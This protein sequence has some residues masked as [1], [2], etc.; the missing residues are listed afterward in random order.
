MGD[1]ARG[2]STGQQAQHTA[3]RGLWRAWRNGTPSLAAGAHSARAKK[4]TQTGF[5]RRRTRRARELQ[6]CS[7][8]GAASSGPAVSPG[9]LSY[10]PY[11]TPQTGSSHI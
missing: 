10:A 7:A 6:C 5:C 11:P 4:A 8:Q 2:Q 9:Y 3:R 1:R